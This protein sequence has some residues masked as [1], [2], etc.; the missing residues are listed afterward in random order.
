MLLSACAWGFPLP[1]RTPG[2]REGGWRNCIPRGLKRPNGGAGELC[3][4]CLTS[5]PTGHPA[6]CLTCGGGCSA[7]P[8]PTGEAPLAPPRPR[9]SHRDPQ[10]LA[11]NDPIRAQGPDPLGL[12]SLCLVPP[13]PEASAHK[14]PLSPPLGRRG[15]RLCWAPAALSPALPGSPCANGS[16]C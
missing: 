15:C 16:L 12:L 8:S 1:L 9:G 2:R 5:E 13:W 7:P 6:Q 3:Q 14:D 11:E 10:M 4:A